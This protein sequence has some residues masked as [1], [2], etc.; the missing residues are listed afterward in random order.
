MTVFPPTPGSE[1][2]PQDSNFLLLFLKQLSWEFRK[3]VAR[4]R[5]HLG[6][7]LVVFFELAVSML[8]RMTPV[9]AKI[10]H[11]IWKMHAHWEDV[12]SGLTTAAHLM[13]EAMTVF[14]SLSLA[15]VAGDIVAK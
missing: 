2:M 4:R 13:G 11:D 5:T 7:G 10:A 6:F 14:G 15:L 8:L 3:L 12:F 9:R 1:P